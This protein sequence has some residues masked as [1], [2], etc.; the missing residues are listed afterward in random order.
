MK[1][2]TKTK[3][4]PRKKLVK[5]LDDICSKYIK[6]RDSYTCQRC[7]K[8]NAESQIHLSHV[9]PRSAGMRLRW[10]ELNSKA[11]CAYCHRRWWHANTLEAT[12]WFKIV[13]PERYEYVMSEKTKG[14]RKFANF[15]LEEMIADFKHKIENM[16]TEDIPF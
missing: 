5:K 6:L 3:T 7:G 11:L 14:S 8:T 1:K 9:I 4:S 16:N 15:E 12:E 10:D 13:F 2:K